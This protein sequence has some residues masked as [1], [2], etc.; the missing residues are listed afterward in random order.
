MGILVILGLALAFQGVRQLTSIDDEVMRMSALSDNNTRVLKIGGLLE[1]AR[2]ASLEYKTSGTPAALEEGD[3]AD[4]QTTG[5]LEVAA[6]ATLSD[7]RRRTYG[8]MVNNVTEFHKLRGDLTALTREIQES[9]ARLFSG[10]DQMSAATAALVPAVQISGDIQIRTAA[11]DVETAILLV[12]VANWRFLA[13]RDPNGPATFRKNAEAAASTLAALGKLPI[14]DEIRRLTAPIEAALTGYSESF[15]IVSNAMLKSDELFDHRMQALIQQQAGAAETTASSLGRDFAATQSATASMISSTAAT[16]K[17]IA[18]AA[19]L[20]GVLIA[21]FAGR[22]IIGPISGMTAA[23]SRLATGETLVD[24]P[25]RDAAD[26]MG[27]MAKAVEVFRQNALARAQLE[28][29]QKE[30]EE[31]ASREK[32]AAL[33]GMAEKIET[34]SGS[35][36]DSVGVHTV[37]IAKAAEE[38]NASAGRA[39]E[40]A[41]GAATAAA[42]ALSNAETVA[43]AAEQLAASIREIGGQ[44]NQSTTVVGR[45]V[46]AGSETRATIEALNEQVGRIGAVADMISEIAAKTNLL[47]LNAT[48]EAARAG[49]AGKGFAVVASEVKQLATQT[50]R[51]TDEI[52]R[53]IADVRTAT[54]ASVAAVGRIE[55]TINEISAIAGSIA[56]SVEEQGAA[57]AEIARNVNETAAAAHEMTRRITEVSAEADRTG[58][59]ST[60]VRDDTAAMSTMVDEL[61][62]S[63]IRVVRTSTEDVNR[64]HEARY[65]VHFEGRISV[66]GRPG[67][68]AMVVD[69]SEHGA[70]VTASPPLPIGTRGTL[71]V[72]RFGMPLPFVVRATE[73]ETMHLSFDLDVA[74]ADRFARMLQ[75]QTLSRAA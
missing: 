24:I 8:M 72:D 3:A 33:L 55:Q 59:R 52:T 11:R 12:R 28:A 43:S 71:E 17:M 14:S 29:A 60:Q 70:A 22:G 48:I 62:H 67:G 46:T 2:R 5:L 53:H 18:T 30:H 40:S 1:T 58:Q 16:Q 45:A 75:Q 73:N 61:K 74:N 6:R 36:L 4:T 69:V 10:G 21:W 19:A 39:S 51:S 32:H 64:R 25:S 63:L 13:T 47:A 23:M 66:A 41:Q 57:T 27:A 15:Q 56:A 20:L 34:A 54:G 26:E 7:E 68:G 38:M 50:A 44:V 42:K 37:A 31:R 9:R 35:A 49:D 65:P